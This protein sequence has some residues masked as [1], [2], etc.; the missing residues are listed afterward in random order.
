MTYLPTISTTVSP[1][2]E[3]ATSTTTASRMSSEPPSLQELFPGYDS[4]QVNEEALGS[5]SDGFES[6][7]AE[8]ANECATTSPAPVPEKEERRKEGRPRVLDYLAIGE[9]VALEPGELLNTELLGRFGELMDVDSGSMAFHEEEWE[10][11][12]EGTVEKVENVV[13]VVGGDEKKDGERRK[14]GRPKEA[15][16][17]ASAPGS[18]VA[19]KRDGKVGG[20][21]G[22]GGRKMRKGVG[23]EEKGGSDGEGTRKRRREAGVVSP[24]SV[25]EGGC[26][27]IVRDQCSRCSTRRQETPMMRKGPD[28][29]RSLCNACGLRWSRHGVF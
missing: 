10:G 9:E 2:S 20:K 13:E 24:T 15:N 6:W 23:G 14:K 29:S 25:V 28:G 18:P 11:N 22:T 7:F 19:A 16:G 17:S 27:M 4:A 12:G 21:G 26:L 8:P 1:M 5:V 3:T